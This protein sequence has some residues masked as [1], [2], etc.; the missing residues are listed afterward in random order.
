MAFI[1][2][3]NIGIS[4]ISA[5]VPK[6]VVKNSDLTHIIPSN[7]IDKTINNIGIKE[8]RFANPDICSS[9]LCLMAANKLLE[10]M[11][12]DKNTIDILIFMSQT[13]D[14]HIP[15]TAPILQHRLG[16]PKST[17][18]FDINLSC[19]GYVYSLATAFAFAS[20]KEINR[21]L[22]LDGETF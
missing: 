2:F 11:N 21:V 6:N 19:S 12:I 3:N 13:P 17:A 7:E 22:L 8:K 20:Q 14:Y 15:A 18:S 16:L 4:G 10:D 9:D 1:T 5:C